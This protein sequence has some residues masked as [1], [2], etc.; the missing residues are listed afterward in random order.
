MEIN[1]QASLRFVLADETGREG[2]LDPE[3]AGQIYGISDSAW[4]EYCKVTEHEKLPLKDISI[5]EV[6]DLYYLLYWKPVRADYAP[7][8]LDYYLFDLSYRFSPNRVNSWMGSWDAFV[9]AGGSCLEVVNS[10]DQLSRRMM[11]STK[12]WETNYTYK[13]NRANR[14]IARARKLIKHAS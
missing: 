12:S 2:S 7:A 11:K 14:A 8:G 9:A 13:T 1:F 4:A 6:A 5:W 3:R 10:L